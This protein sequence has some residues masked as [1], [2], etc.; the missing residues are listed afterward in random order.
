VGAARVLAFVVLPLVSLL[1]IL[2]VALFINA[3]PRQEFGLAAESPT[4]LLPYQRI[5]HDQVHVY[6][7]KV[8]I[9]I[10]NT[11][12]ASFAA[13]GSMLPVLGPTAHA[14]QIV[15]KSPDE[16]HVGDI[17]SFRYDN[18]IISH[19]VINIGDDKDGIYFITK[20]DN[21]PVQDPILVRFDQV[22]RILVGILY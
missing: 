16:I 18:K 14:L 11:R 1:F 17:I 15:P 9:D 6:G 10:P 19:R 3:L 5:S 12:W 7:D 4:G 13:T 8:E 2:T 21:N 20:G 22:D